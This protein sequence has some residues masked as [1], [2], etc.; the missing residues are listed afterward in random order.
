MGHAFHRVLALSLV[1]AVASCHG[2]AGDSVGALA[3]P[4]WGQVPP[5]A[6][7]VGES[8]NGKRDPHDGRGNDRVSRP[9]ALVLDSLM[10]QP[11]V[12]PLR[13]ADTT[14]SAVT[15]AGDAEK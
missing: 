6:S 3:M 7:I 11:H 2:D 12:R 4:G 15:S 14:L 13:A 8:D 9:N 10:G 5:I 1:A